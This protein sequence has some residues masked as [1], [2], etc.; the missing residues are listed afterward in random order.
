MGFNSGFK[1]LSGVA[2]SGH[3]ALLLF[4]GTVT[5]LTGQGIAMRS[6]VISGGYCRDCSNWDERVVRG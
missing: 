2:L 3:V 4:T 6:D 1:G 5:H